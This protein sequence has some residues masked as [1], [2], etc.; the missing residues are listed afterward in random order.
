MEEMIAALELELN[1]MDLE[2]A[3]LCV[4]RARLDK[5]WEDIQKERHRVQFLI[6]QL[7]AEANKEAE[8]H[9]RSGGYANLD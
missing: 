4:E 2:L 6:A 8:C 9:Q 1:G 3:I 5:L 7:K